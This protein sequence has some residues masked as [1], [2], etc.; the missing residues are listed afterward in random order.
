MEWDDGRGMAWHMIARR[1]NGENEQMNIRLLHGGW[2]DGVMTMI[3]LNW[4][5]WIE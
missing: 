5:G 4:I 3:L 1:R 2:M